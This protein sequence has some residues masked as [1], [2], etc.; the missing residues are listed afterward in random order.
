MIIF[1]VYSILMNQNNFSNISLTSLFFMFIDFKENHSIYTRFIYIRSRKKY[2]SCRQ[3]IFLY[4]ICLFPYN[5]V[6]HNRYLKENWNS[7]RYLYNRNL[8]VYIKD[9]KPR[10]CW[11]TKKV[12]Q[13]RLFRLHMN[14]F[15]RHICYTMDASNYIYFSCMVNLQSNLF[16]MMLEE[17]KIR[18]QELW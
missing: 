10:S 3:D 16:H 14:Y 2:F 9:E 12:L 8:Y 1:N 7:F 13:T 17:W 4:L 15:R 18:K 6:S 11:I 5:K